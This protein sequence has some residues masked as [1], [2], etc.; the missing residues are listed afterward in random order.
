MAAPEGARALVACDLDGTV[1]E[2]DGSPVPGVAEALAELVASGAAF[3]VC[4]GRPLQSAQRATEAL[5]VDPSG[6][7]CYHGALVVSRSGEAIRHLPLPRDT[8][9]AVAGEAVRQGLGVTVYDVDESRELIA[10]AGPADEPGDH[11]SRL[12]LHGEAA[13][14][15]RLF[16]GLRR[17][18]DGRL[19]IEQIRPGFVG[20][21]HRA[22]DKGDALRLLAGHLGVPPGKVA[23][24]GDSSQDESLLAAAAVR[25]A[26]GGRPHVLGRLPGVVVTSRARLAETLRAQ[27][28]PL[29]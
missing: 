17:E 29:L 27:V 13:T 5:G 22:A 9:R 25:I 10:G 21:F 2:D 1:L 19:R 23:A 16:A 24:C 12:V 26:V 6:L 15:A 20:V 14:A 18:W 8:A 7:A 3:V 4:T 11:V 28:R